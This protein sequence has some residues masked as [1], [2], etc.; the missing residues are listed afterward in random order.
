MWHRQNKPVYIQRQC[1]TGSSPVTVNWVIIRLYILGF[2]SRSATG[3]STL[4]FIDM[5][6]FA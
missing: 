5:S 3:I 2:P 1:H 4:L 6:R